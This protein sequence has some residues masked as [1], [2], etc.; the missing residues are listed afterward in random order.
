MSLIRIQDGCLAFG[1]VALLDRIELN[2]E[3]GE[4]VCLIGRNGTG[5]STLL[6]VLSGELLLDSGQLWRR[7]GVKVAKLAQEVPGTADATLFEVVAAGLG[8]NSAL[9]ARYHHSSHLL[10][11]KGAHV[12][13]A[14]L[15]AFGRLQAELENAGAWEGSERV[16]AVLSRLVL[17]PDARMS[18]CSGGV[19]RRAM[20][21]QALVSQ[22]D[23]LLLDEPTNHLDIEA[24][25]AL[26]EA[27]LGYQGAVVFI[28]HDRS[29]IDHL[30][31][32]IIEL[33]RGTLR[34]FPGSYASYLKRK[35]AILE[36]EADSNRK[37]D[38]DLAAEEV[39]IRQGIKA[40]RT[41]NEGRVRRL[42]AMRRERAE[43]RSTSGNVRMSLA[44]NDRSGKLVLEAEDVSFSY[45]G[46]PVVCNFSTLITR[47]DRIGIIG[48]NGTGKT[49][50]LK[51]LLGEL[52]PTQGSIRQGTQLEIA[53]FDQERM[54]LDSERS[55]RDNLADGADQIEVAGKSRHVISYLADFLFAP[56]RAQSPV[57]TLSGGERN[58]LLLA[59]LFS[60]PANLLVLDEPTNDLDV[61]T[62]E[63]LEELLSEYQGTL[64]LVSHDRS[65]IDATVT[66]TLWLP[67]DGSVEEHVGGYSDWQRRQTRPGEATAGRQ[68]AAGARGHTETPVTVDR[69]NAKQRQ[70]KLSYREQREL[71]ALPEQIEQLEARQQALQTRT[72][73]PEF[74]QS[75][76]DTVAAALAELAEVDSQL[77]A[78]YAR[79]EAIEHM[80]AP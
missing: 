49:T 40:R 79:W 17:P 51:L 15:A 59:K 76:K 33:D 21:G 3:H 8:D 30:A 39:W 1:H 66:S 24:I 7:D 71:D 10:A 64:L 46:D 36:A 19:R 12:S 52:K 75:D 78:A 11:E 56:A 50:L 32:R 74:Y 26:E 37:F 67:G 69:A 13:E 14:E 2:V 55:V 29:L 28:T 73:D 72:A 41:R 58:R 31:T 20:L 5:K 57:K 45:N 77:A 18:E 61:E 16:D 80:Q 22:P 63:L 54:Q 27:L 9:L 62:L 25:E 34:S 68:N 6:N 42:Q 23:L 65:F 70:R 38:K 47:G 60:R 44:D 4:R 48:R 35:A 43:R 53:Y